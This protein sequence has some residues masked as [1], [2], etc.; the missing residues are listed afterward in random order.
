VNLFT[1]PADEGSRLAVALELAPATVTRASVELRTPDDYVIAGPTWRP[2]SIEAEG[3]VTIAG[4]QV[5]RVD[6]DDHLAGRLTASLTPPLGRVFHLA[7]A[8]LDSQDGSSTAPW[9][10][11][12][13]ALAQLEPG[14]TLIVHDG[15]WTSSSACAE[16]PCLANTALPNV[17]CPAAARSGTPDHPIA[18]VARHQRRAHLAGN[19]FGGVFQVRGCDSWVIDGLYGSNTDAGPELTSGVVFGFRDTPRLTMRHLLAVGPNR[20]GN[21]HVIDVGGTTSVDVVIEDSEVYKFHRNAFQ[22]SGMTSVTMRRNYIH[23]RDT[24][25]AACS[26]TEFYPLRGDAGVQCRATTTCTADNVFAENVVLGFA[27]THASSMRVAGSLARDTHYGA[28]LTDAPILLPEPMHVVDFVCLDCD[29][30]LWNR[31]KQLEATNATVVAG[32]ARLAPN[33]GVGAYTDDAGGTTGSTI[34]RNVLAL[35][36]ERVGFLTAGPVTSL[37]RYG[38]AYG[39]PVLYQPTEELG[40]DTG[41]IQHS[42]DVEPTL[43]GDRDGA[44]LVHVPADSNMAGAGEGGAALGANIVYRLDQGQPTDRKL[45]NQRTGAFPCG[46]LVPGVNDIAGASCFDAHL[47]MRVGV[48]GCAIP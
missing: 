47:R 2:S 9:Q 37:I 43:I 3:L 40:D 39:S 28:I 10:T 24:A 36:N 12:P 14:D 21:N 27:H 5:V 18:I 45:W 42:L 11:W 31:G 30:G 33:Y 6:S 19:G 17:D 34:W 44:C 48:A 38:N 1:V 7:V 15:T 4:V 35:D 29:V 23:S 8:G 22:V 20:C 25:E 26:T 32:R 13:F 46:A 16:E 41:E